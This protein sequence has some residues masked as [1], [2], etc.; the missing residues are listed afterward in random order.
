M[1]KRPSPNRTKPIA[2][3]SRLSR[4]DSKRAATGAIASWAAPDT[5]MISPAA[6]EFQVPRIARER[7]E[8]LQ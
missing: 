8:L 3:R 1:L 5:I 4:G 6:A 7:P 2:T